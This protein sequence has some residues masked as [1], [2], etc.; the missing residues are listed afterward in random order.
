MF[1]MGPRAI[2]DI[3]GF[4]FYVYTEHPPAHVHVLMADGTVKID[5]RTLEEMKRVNMHTRYVK[6][7]IR[8]VK[9]HRNALIAEWNKR[10]EEHKIDL[11]SEV[12][13]SLRR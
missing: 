1:F 5:L 3:D 12:G 4:E 10:N 6:R 8:L 9:V 2:K 11:P 7:A 13:R